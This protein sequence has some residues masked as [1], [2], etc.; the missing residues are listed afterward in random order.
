MDAAMKSQGFVFWMLVGV[1]LSSASMIGCGSGAGGTGSGASSEMREEGRA[2]FGTG[3]VRTGDASGRDSGRG[4]GNSGGGSG[5]N[6]GGSDGWAVLLEFVRGAGHEARAQE[7]RRAWA[8][9]LGRGDVTVRGR[10]SGSAVVLG[11]YRAADDRAAQRDL[12]M[13]KNLEVNGQRP[14]AGAYLL[15]PPAPP[16]EMGGRPEWNLVSVRNMPAG[17]TALYSL[18]IGVFEGRNRQRLAEDE[19]ARL[20][21][22]G[23]QAFY[24]HGADRSAVTIGLF[25]EDAYGSRGVSQDVRALQ[26]KFPHMMRNGSER[27]MTPEGTPEPTILVQIPR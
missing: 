25:G 21:R 7:R 4:G 18:H 26:M 13:V 10:E 3:G 11:S 19:V 8:A 1:L 5:G 27:M 2:V 17:R 15:P 22:L 23:E 16:H 9:E 14:F 6:S 24:F 12:A 20:R